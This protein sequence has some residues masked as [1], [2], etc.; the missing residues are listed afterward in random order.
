[1][2]FVSLV[3]F[4]SS[5]R[6]AE[7]SLR[8]QGEL[9]QVTLASIGDAVIATDVNGRVNF[10]NPTAAAITGWDAGAASGKAFD[11][12][13]QIINEDTGEPIESPFAIVK[14]EGKVL[15]LA[16]THC[17]D[18]ARRPQATDQDSGAPIRDP[19]GNMIGVIVVFDTSER[20]RIEQEREGLLLG[21]REAR[22]KP[23]RRTVL[24]MSFW[25]LSPMNCGR[26]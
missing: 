3:L 8:E 23:K 14:R 20:R 21:E 1:M 26:L 6:K 9:L 11:E 18:H 7:K 10:I 16:Q 5:R 17:F 2:L 4:A 25:R 24:K 13:F 15:G 22:R 12:V 19:D